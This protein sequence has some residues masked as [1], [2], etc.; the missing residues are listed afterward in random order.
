M[1]SSE[2]RPP[3]PSLGDEQSARLSHWLPTMTCVGSLATISGDDGTELKMTEATTTTV[4]RRS[5]RLWAGDGDADGLE[6]IPQGLAYDPRYGSNSSSDD[7]KE[8]S[9]SETRTPLGSFELRMIP[10]IDLGIDL[11]GMFPTTPEDMGKQGMFDHYYISI[12]ARGLTWVIVASCLQEASTCKSTI[13]GR[14]INFGAVLP[15]SIYRSSFPA[16]E[17]LSFLG[18][19]GLKTVL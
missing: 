2:V 11:S 12:R 15:G 16:P 18:T 17:N 3:I 9:L 8:L 10:V 4:S 7:G 13:N 14:P 5:T 6:K 1:A 19:L